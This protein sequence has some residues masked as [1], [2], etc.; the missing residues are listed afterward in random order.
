MDQNRMPLVEA[1]QQFREEAPAYFRIPGHR[2]E[3]GL[4]EALNGASLAAYDLSEAEGL[5]DLHHAE[6]VI[7]EAQRLAAETWKAKKTFFLVNGTT[8]GN[9]A[10]VL[11]SVKEGEKIIVPRNVH[12]SVLMGLILCGATPVYVMPEY[13]TKW[14]MW[15]GV[16]PETIENA[17]AETPDA[18]AV[19]LVSPTYYGLCS[20]LQAIAEICH[21]HNAA[22]LVDEAHGSH[23][24]FSEQLPLG[25]LESGADACAQSIHK[26]A[27]SF[28][29]SSF[30]SLGSGRLDEA[31]V[32]ANLQMV[33]S[34]SPSYLLMASLD[35]ARRGM[36]LHGKERMERALELGQ[37]ARQELAKIKGIEVLGTE[38]EGTC[39]VWKIDPTRGIPRQY[40]ACRRGERGLR[41]YLGKQRGRY[42]TAD[43]CAGRNFGSRERENDGADEVY[44]KA[45]AV[46]QPAG[47]GKD[48]A[49]GIFCGERSRSVCR[50]GRTNCSRDGSPISAGNPAHLPGRA[51]Q[52][53]NVGTDAPV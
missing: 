34:T 39:G 52:Q 19:L 45:V 49:R 18:K 1:L 5:D 36:A 26:T 17:F 53:R 32:A 28:T 51:V 24:Y 27:G 11:S 33:Q 2:F 30:L 22:L 10:M 7:A 50:S 6:G 38:M 42:H 12:K 15:G 20:D 41:Y 37:R 14:Q 25:A 31:R 8:C 21:C 43:R 3:R 46:P 35:A 13:S 44:R 47:D 16:T 9:E 29:Q 48:T 4:D 40:R 23:L